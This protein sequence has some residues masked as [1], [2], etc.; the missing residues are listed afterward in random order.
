MASKTQ[1]LEE[2]RF[3]ANSHFTLLASFAMMSR[4]RTI[5]RG[6]AVFRKCFDDLLCG[7]NRRW[8]LCDIE[9]DDTATIVGQ[10]NEH[11]EDTRK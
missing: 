9:V 6:A 7:P 5:N 4:S 3:F 10:D 2:Q 11:I 8:M 1:A